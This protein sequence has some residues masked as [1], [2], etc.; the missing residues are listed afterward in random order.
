MLRSGDARADG[1][2]VVILGCLVGLTIVGERGGMGFIIGLFGSK[3]VVVGRGVILKLIC[4]VGSRVTNRRRIAARGTMVSS[5]IT[6][7]PR[8]VKRR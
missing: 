7:T 1:V 6:M 5:I 8:R 3:G 2:G 4:P